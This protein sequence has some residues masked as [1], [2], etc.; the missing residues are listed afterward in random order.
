MRGNHDKRK[1]IIGDLTTVCHGGQFHCWSDNSYIKIGNDCMFS[2]ETDIMNGDAHPIYDINTNNRL[3][4]GKYV[5][6]GEHCWIGA[7]VTITKNVKLAYGTIIGT[8]SVIS[9]SVDEPN[10]ILIGNPQQ[11]IKKNVYWTRTCD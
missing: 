8:R 6:I 9:K 11:I 2:Y 5:E 1:I 3:N 4:Y 10:C 7:K